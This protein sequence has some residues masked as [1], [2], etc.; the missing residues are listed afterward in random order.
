[1]SEESTEQ[2]PFVVVLE[3][4]KSVVVVNH[5]DVDE[6]DDCRLII[7]FNHD[8]E[9]DPKEVEA[10]LGRVLLEKLEQGLDAD[11]NTTKFEVEKK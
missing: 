2:K 5:I 3:K 10:E 1:M 9:A 8:I 11:P 4:F 6:S 7:D